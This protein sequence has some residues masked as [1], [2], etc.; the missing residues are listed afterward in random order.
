M[1]VLL[2]ADP[3]LATGAPPVAGSIAWSRA[4]LAR[5]QRTMRTLQA[6]HASLLES[7]FGQMVR[8]WAADASRALWPNHPGPASGQCPL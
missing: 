7:S 8:A 4:L 1:R 6:S 5:M 2:Q 3:P